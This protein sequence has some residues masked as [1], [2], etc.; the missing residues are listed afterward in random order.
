M[1]EQQNKFLFLNNEAGYSEL[2]T[3]VKSLSQNIFRTNNNQGS[4][5]ETTSTIVMQN[6][7]IK[8][9]DVWWLF[10]YW[11]TETEVTQKVKYVA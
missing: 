1:K 11:I 10:Q 9:I 2:I 3:H 4:L 7:T 5:V 6:I 8:S